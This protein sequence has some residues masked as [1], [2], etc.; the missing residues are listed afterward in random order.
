MDIN[1]L[2][3]NYWPLLI[4]ALLKLGAALLV[5]AVTLFVAHLA[6]R[7]IDRLP[8]R[9][10]VT[11]RPVL[12][13][14]SSWAIYIV[15]ALLV[16]DA[17]GVNTTSLIALLG[18]T[19]V[20]VALALKDTLQ[21]IASGFIL[22]GLRP[23]RVGDVIQF[24]STMGTVR[25][26]GLFTTEMDATD[27]LRITAPNNAIWG[28]TLTNFSRNKTRR[29]EIVA[30]IAYGDDIEIGLAVLRRLVAAE[31]RLLVEP[32]PS[33]TVRALADSAVNLQLRAWASTEEYW[34]VYWS[35]MKQLKPA[36]EAAGLTVPFPQRELH[37]VDRSS[38][39]H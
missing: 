1:S 37:I 32:E 13:S 22:L 14:I 35:M 7:A 31:P 28:Q 2:A 19:G 39:K 34:E 36:L 18:A 27:G 4:A 3:S 17:F 24:G 38:S 12:R 33:Y 23:F 11:L 21:N 10:D 15:G 8:E 6:R 26:V 25:E 20:A 30:S 9:F 29:I 5:V 16:L